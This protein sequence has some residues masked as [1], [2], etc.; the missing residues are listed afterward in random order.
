M[1]RLSRAGWDKRLPLVLD[2]VIVGY[3]DN[4]TFQ[5]DT[6]YYINGTVTWNHS[7]VEGG[8]CSNILQVLN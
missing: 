2:Y 1:A 3:G 7:T 6:T 4:Y 5:G 8:A